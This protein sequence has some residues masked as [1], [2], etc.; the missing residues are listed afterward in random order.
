MALRGRLCTDE[1]QAL[2]EFAIAL[3][4]MALIIFGILELTSLY[5]CRFIVSYAEFMSARCI[6]V[7]PGDAEAVAQDASRMVVGTALDPK[8]LV[9]VV[10]GTIM[11]STAKAGQSSVQVDLR[12]RRVVT[13]PVVA[14]A[15]SPMG[16]LTGIHVASM[17][18]SIVLPMF[19]AK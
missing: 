13:S 19:V 11:K 2:V 17:G 12:Y 7:H 18:S 5:K 3:P 9:P 10:G 1:G 16:R 14:A 8:V 6:S 4:L 15:L